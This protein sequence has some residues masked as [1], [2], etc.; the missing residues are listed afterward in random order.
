MIIFFIISLIPILFLS[1]QPPF[2]PEYS[3]C[4]FFELHKKGNN[5]HIE[6]Y[7]RQNRTQTDLEPLVIKGTG[8]Q[9]SLEKWYELLKPILPDKTFE[10]ECKKVEEEE[11]E[12]KK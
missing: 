10:E 4:L 12:V 8:T 1:L 5:Y 11:E 7:H 9:L 3:S 2:Y 6:L